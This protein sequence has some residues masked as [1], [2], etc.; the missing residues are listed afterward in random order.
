LLEYASKYKAFPV[1][2]LCECPS[3]VARDRIAN[4]IRDDKDTY[5]ERTWE[6]H[7]RIQKMFAPLKE[8]TYLKLDTRLDPSENA[9]KIAEYLLYTVE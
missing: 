4:R 9:M 1:I 5:A 6:E 3:E 2:V 7:K 8:L